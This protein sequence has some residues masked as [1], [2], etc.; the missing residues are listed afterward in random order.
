VLAVACAAVWVIGGR[1]VAPA[2]AVLPPVV[3]GLDTEAVH[4]ASD[5]GA[6]LRGWFAPGD[7]GRGGVVLMHAIRGNRGQMVP[8]MRLLRGAG[9]SVLAFD[10]QAHGESGGDAITLGAR[11]SL[12]ARSA[13]RWVHA[14]L[15]GEPVG[16]IGTSLGGA[17]AV[18]ATP[19]L[20]LQ[21]L[22]I[23]A[24]Y[25][26]LREATENR[27]ALHLGTPGRWLTPLLLWQLKPR[28]EVDP[29][30]LS[31]VRRI[32]GLR[33]PVLVIAGTEDRHTTLEQSRRLFAAA[34]EPKELWEIQG[35]THVDFERFAPEEY[36]SRVLGFLDAHM[37]GGR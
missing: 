32:G 4:F 28:L 16:A 20:E 15:P 3:P 27:L 10:L 37:G 8:R 29:D 25:T 5:S 24:V 6:E 34:P 33:C 17:A 26:D 22:V 2:R 7:P 18:L 19:P 31:P 1:L 12:Y 9:Y 21:A 36:A 14:R 35:A 11:E 13:V 23:E 30:E